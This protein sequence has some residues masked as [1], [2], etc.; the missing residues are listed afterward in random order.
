[1]LSGAREEADVEGVAPVALTDGPALARLCEENEV[2]VVRTRIPI[3][4][5][6][7]DLLD[8]LRAS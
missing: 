6:D 7:V 4:I 1:M 5:V 2:A 3:S 8:A